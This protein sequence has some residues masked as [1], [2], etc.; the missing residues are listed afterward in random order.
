MRLAALTVAL[1]LAAA[2]RPLDAGAPIPDQ[3]GPRFAPREL[4]SGREL[5]LVPIRPIDGDT[6]AIGAETI[7]IENIDTPEMAPRAR[8][9]AEAR[10]AKVAQEELV[11]VI[12]QDWGRLPEV[13]RSGRD[14]YGRTLARVALSDGTDVGE[15]LIKRGV[16]ET[17]TGRRA[18]WCGVRE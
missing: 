16:A 15:E 17:W 5:P 4:G 3:A 9:L 2:C 18:D 7:R 14:R 8:C 1:G 11:R 10:L 13:T 12:G 6:F